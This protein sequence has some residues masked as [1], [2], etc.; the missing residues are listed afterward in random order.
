[1]YHVDDLK[2]FVSCPRSYFY[3]REQGLNFNNF[4]RSDETIELLLAR[5]LGVENYY[6]GLTNDSNGRF[7]KEKEN[8]LWF[9][10][11]RFEAFDLRVKI[12]LMH[13]NNK[14]Y[15]VYFI[16]KGISLKNL[17]LFYYRVNLEVLRLVGIN[18]DNIYIAYINGDYVYHKKLDLNKLFIIC[19]IYEDKKIIDLL[20]EEV[21]DYKEIIKRIEATN[22]NSYSVKSRSICHSHPIC[23]YYNNCH[24]DSDLPDN[25]ILTLVSSKYKEKMYKEGIRELKD[26]SLDLL[27]GERVQYAQIMADKKGGLYVSNY[28][29]KKYLKKLEKRPITF[30]DFEWDAYLIPQY[31]K[32]KPLS[33]LP[34][35]F[36]MYILN[37]KGEL[38]HYSFV[39]KGDCRKEFVEALLKYLPKSGPIVAYN[40][41]GAECY[42]IKELAEFYVKYK[43]ELLNINKRFEDLATPFLEGLIYD[44]RMRG[45]F[46]LK[47][48]V[49]VVS[50][51]NYKSLEINDGVKAVYSW[52]DFDKD[53]E[54]IDNEKIV[55]NLIEYCSL[56][57]Y[58]LY[59]VYKWLTKQV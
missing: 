4:L 57:A 53:K 8:Y 3:F 1:M 13:K 38:S 33:V 5:Y 25:S 22:L 39:G 55:N 44:T 21:V 36:V 58:G 41:Y 10:K 7:L 43:K 12:P 24:N 32:M 49:G 15:D 20:E 6:L 45:N 11:T 17:D 2:K 40:A 31:E 14:G 29:L 42:R 34:F 52:R 59:L 47:K 26:V 46:S 50:N 18:I 37:K 51:Y 27:E 48:L 16:H 56:D 54:N 35:E 23:P 30:I 19:D 9:I 28:A